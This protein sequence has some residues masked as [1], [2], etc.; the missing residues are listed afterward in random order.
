MVPDQ[1]GANPH[2]LVQAGKEGRLLVLNRDNLGGYADGASS[3]TNAL[4]QISNE[5]KGLW[6]TPAYWNGNVYT[7]G[8][9]D[10]PKLFEVNS[11]VLNTTPS[12]KSTVSSAFPGASFSISSDGTQNGIAWAMREDQYTTHGSGVLYAWD[13]TNLASLFYESDTNSARD[14][15]GRANKFAVPVITN[16]KVYVAA[17]GQVDVYGLFNG[18]PNA[19]APV[20]SPDGGTFGGA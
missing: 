6:S 17:W 5:I 20:I 7:W 18:E 2:I 3:D 19:V 4:Q 14:G 12:S 10:V 13:A 9:G 1:Q 16:G 8:N 15:A 11:G